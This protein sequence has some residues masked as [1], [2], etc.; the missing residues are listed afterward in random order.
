MSSPSLM[1][2]FGH[3]G[4]QAPQLMHSSAIIVAMIVLLRGAKTCR[5]YVN[6]LGASN[7]R[8]GAYA[9]IALQISRGVDIVKRTASMVRASLLALGPNGHGACGTCRNPMDG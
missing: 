3:S 6:G 9:P 2:S 4:S 7:K 5:S 1:A 8:A